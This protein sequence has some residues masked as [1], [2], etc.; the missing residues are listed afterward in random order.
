MARQRNLE[1]ERIKEC[2]RLLETAQACIDALWMGLYKMI[3]FFLV[4][5]GS[6]IATTVTDT[7]WPLLFTIPAVVGFVLC[8]R[9]NNVLGARVDKCH[10]RVDYLCNGSEAQ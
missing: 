4:A 6:A 10:D 8:Q 5:V 1:A 3:A 7:W 9:Q 2:D